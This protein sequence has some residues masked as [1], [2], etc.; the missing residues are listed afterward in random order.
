MRARLTAIVIGAVATA[1]LLA[2]CG[3]SDGAA[4]GPEGAP[5]EVPREPVATTE[6][7]LPKSYRFVPAVIEIQAGDTV[8][9]ANQDEFPHNV[10]LLDGSDRS[11][12]LP[13][14]ESGS[15][16]FADPERS[17]TSARSTPSRCTA[18]SS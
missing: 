4:S 7:S 16:T 14:G 3:S 1:L 2:A 8:T 10:H 12:D 18:R 15:I 17:T 6:V 9:W 11:A 5:F 13:I